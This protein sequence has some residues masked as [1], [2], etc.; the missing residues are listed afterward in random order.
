MFFNWDTEF[1]LLET[2]DRQRTNGSRKS[3][4]G[5][6]GTTRFISQTIKTPTTKTEA[7][8]YLEPAVSGRSSTKPSLRI[9]APFRKE[10]DQSKKKKI[11][12][13]SRRNRDR[14]S[15]TIRNA[16]IVFLVFWLSLPPS[17][18]PPRN[19]NAIPLFS[20]SLKTASKP[21][22]RRR[23]FTESPSLHCFVL[24]YNLSLSIRAIPFGA[25]AGWRIVR[26]APIESN[27]FIVR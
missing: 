18:F 12:S 1:H 16:G 9:S 14:F 27:R 8:R 5:G 2:H 20:T 22:P 26:G 23:R 17:W 19:R 25:E 13:N 24:L 10:T 15:R 6:V 7:I 11:V 3:E 21:P 4:G